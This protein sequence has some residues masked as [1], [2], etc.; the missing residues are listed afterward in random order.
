V[1]V[2]VVGLLAAMLPHW[3]LEVLGLEH[4]G[5]AIMAAALLHL[6]VIMAVLAAAAQAASAQAFLVLIIMEAMV[7]LGYLLQ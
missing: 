3:Q 1:A 7:A 4:R 6:L 2:L 5:K